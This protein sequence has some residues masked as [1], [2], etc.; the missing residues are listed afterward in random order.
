MAAEENGGFGGCGGCRHTKRQTSSHNTVDALRLKPILFIIIAQE[1][2]MPWHHLRPGVTE[3][4]LP[5]TTGHT[6]ITYFFK[7]IVRSRMSSERDAF[8][9]FL[10]STDTSDGGHATRLHGANTFNLSYSILLWAQERVM[11]G[12]H[13][14]LSCN[15]PTPPPETTLP[16]YTGANTYN[17]SFQ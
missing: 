17:P 2:A 1:G 14:R 7:N 6:I 16:D 8:R 11:S 12:T 3:A 9:S 5:D 15:Q 10:Q 13:L 4:T